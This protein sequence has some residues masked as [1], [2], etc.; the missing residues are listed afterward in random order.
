[1]YT[2]VYI[3]IRRERNM[4]CA[5]EDFFQ[6]DR[7]AAVTVDHS[8]PRTRNSYYH[9]VYTTRDNI[10][11]LI[12]ADVVRIWYNITLYRRSGF[13]KTLYRNV[14]RASDVI[15]NKCIYRAHD[16]HGTER[17]SVVWR[18]GS[19]NRS[20]PTN[21]ENVDSLFLCFVVPAFVRRVV[22]FVHTRDNNRP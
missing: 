9:H 2:C 12:R 20:P 1:M 6:I 11:T 18:N 7:P 3:C 10:N 13:K 19:H 8:I 5:C 14:C 16:D 21:V 17:L 22:W 15:L 4:T